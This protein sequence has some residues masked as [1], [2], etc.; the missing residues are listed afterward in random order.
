MEYNI[1]KSEVVE[2]AR[3]A[4]N[5]VWLLIGIMDPIVLLASIIASLVLDN[6]AGV[7]IGITFIAISNLGMAAIVALSWQKVIDLLEADDIT[8][9]ID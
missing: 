4:A 6:I 7:I 5:K 8:I 2:C 1:K 3:I 9:T